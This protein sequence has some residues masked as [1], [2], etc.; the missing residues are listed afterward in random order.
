MRWGIAALAALALGA[1]F[2][3]QYTAWLSPYYGAVTRMLASGH[4]WSIEQV[5]LEPGRDGTSALT[6]R[7]TVR[8]AADKRRPNAAVV[9]QLRSGLVIQTAMVFW[10]VL[11][12]WPTRLVRQRP[13]RVLCA[14]PVY[15]LLEIVTTGVQ[16]IHG[17]PGIAQLLRGNAYRTTTLDYWAAFLEEGGRIV[18]AIVAALLALQ[19]A[20]W[21]EARSRTSKP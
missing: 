8:L 7:A 6:L 14:L 12:A 13:L 21:L 19:L 15:L 16:L 10:L 5:Q 17:L 4:P 18:L 3:D 1:L 11:L 2:A 9:E 20:R